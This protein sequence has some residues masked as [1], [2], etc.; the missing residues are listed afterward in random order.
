MT[1]EKKQ[2]RKEHRVNPKVIWY[3]LLLV[4]VHGMLHCNIWYVGDMMSWQ[5]SNGDHNPIV[6]LHYS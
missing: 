1:T 3:T 4:W 5:Y 6:V 2:P